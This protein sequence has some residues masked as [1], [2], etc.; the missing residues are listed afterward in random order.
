[1]KFN[2]STTANT[3]IYSNDM[4]LFNETNNS[5]L[6]YFTSF[7]EE[8][9][10]DIITEDTIEHHMTIK[11]KGHTE[12][13]TSR[14]LL[15]PTVSWTTDDKISRQ[16]LRVQLG[17]F[18][19]IASEK[20]DYQD[21]TFVDVGSY[22]SQSYEGFQ[23]P[24]G[25]TTIE[26]KMRVCNKINTCSESN[27]T[28][29]FHVESPVR[30]ELVST[31]ELRNSNVS[32][33]LV[34]MNGIPFQADSG[35]LFHQWSL[36]LDEACKRQISSWKL[37]NITGSTFEVNICIAPETSL[38]TNTYGC[39][40]AFSTAGNE[41]TSCAKTNVSNTNTDRT[42]FDF[43]LTSNAWKHVLE[44]K[45]SSN[46]GEQYEILQ[47][48]ELDFANGKSAVVGVMLYADQRN[49]TWYLVTT[50]TL[51]PSGD[52]DKS[53][54]CQNSLTTGNGYATFDITHLMQNIRYYICAFADESIVEREYSTEHLSS[55]Q[56]CS[57]GFVVDREPPSAGNVL[58][59]N[60]NGFVANL[61]SIKI[62]WKGFADNVHSSM[63][64]YDRD[65]DYYM[66]AIG[67]RRGQD[68][69]M[70]FR[71]VGH[72]HSVNE[73][74]QAVLNGASFFVTVKAVDFAG[75]E[76]KVSS[77]EVLVDTTPPFVGDIHIQSNLYSPRYFSSHILSV[78]LSNFMDHE[79]GIDFFEVCIGTYV[80]LC[81]TVESKQESV[82]VIE[83]AMENALRDGSTYFIN[84]KA[85]NRAG[86]PS[87]TVSRS[88]SFD[89]SPPELG[90]VFDGTRKD[91]TDIDFQNTSTEI[92]IHW[93]GFNDPH[94]GMA[95]YEVGLGTRPF[96]DNVESIINVGLREDFKWLDNF[97][98]GTR[99][100]ATVNACNN[101]GLC[102][103]RTSNG[104][105]ID[106]SP[107]IQGLVSIGS[108]S[109]HHR[110]VANRGSVTVQWVGFQ[111]PES[112]LDHFDICIGD[113]PSNCKY[114]PY[115]HC[116]L[117]N[118]IV[119]TGLSLPENINL[120][121][122]VRAFN[123]A[124]IFTNQ[125]S[126]YFRIDTTAPVIFERPQ[127]RH[128][129]SGVSSNNGQ[130]ER[131]LLKLKWKF[132]DKQ[133]PI[134]SH[135]L[136]LKTHHDGH[137]PVEYLH[138]GNID[139]LTISLHENDLLNNGDKYFVTVTGCNL[140]DLCT[141]AISENITVDSS[142]P[143]VGG[144]KPPLNWN[145]FKKNGGEMLSNVTLTWYGFI[146][147]ES[148]IESYFITLSRTYSGNEL[149]NE[150]IVVTASNQH[151]EMNTSITLVET[152]KP[153]DIVI[154]SIWAMNKIGLNSSVSRTSVL[155]LSG[156]SR[157]GN[158]STGRL[159][160][161]K[162]SCDV[163]FC[164]SD[165]TC[166]VFGKPC[167]MKKDN[168]T[169]NSMN[170]SEIANELPTLRVV[171]GL[172]ET[173]E[174]TTASSNCL[175]G[176]WN[177][178]SGNESAFERYEWSA[179]L[180]NQPIG[181]GSDVYGLTNVGV[182]TQITFNTSSLLHGTRY[183][184]TV[185]SYNILGLHTTGNSDGFMI[186]IDI[187]I[188]GTVFN[189]RSFSN[190][191]FQSST[192]EFEISWY[193]F[194]DHLSGIRS[195]EV[196][197][198]EASE[199]KQDLFSLYFDE[200]A[201]SDSIHLNISECDM[202]IGHVLDVVKVRQIGPSTIRV[203][204]FILD[205]E[206]GIRKWSLGIGTTE[207]GYQL[208]TFQNKFHGSDGIVSLNASHG[209]SIFVTVI[210]ENNAGL[211][212]TLKGNTIKIDRTPPD[213]V[214]IKAEF[215]ASDLNDTIFA[216]W[217]AND[218]ESG[219]AYCSCGLGN[220]GGQSDIIPMQV[221]DSIEGC[222]LVAIENKSE[223]FVNVVCVN[224]M[225]L[226]TFASTKVNV[227]RHVPTT[228][229]AIVN[230]VPLNEYSPTLRDCDETTCTQSNQNKLCLEW[231]G[232]QDVRYISGY[233]YRILVGNFSERKW[234]PCKRHTFTEVNIRMQEN[235]IYTAE[236]RAINRIGHSA[237]VSKD[238]R[239]LP[240]GP[241]LT[242]Q[243][244]KTVF[245]NSTLFLDWQS[246]FEHTEFELRYDVMIGSQSG[247]TDLLELQ[248]TGSLQY[249][250]PVPTSTIVSPVITELHITINAIGLTGFQTRYGFVY[251]Y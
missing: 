7:T 158:I 16:S 193:G 14:A 170:V 194:T 164:N 136:T 19:D 25:V 246:V 86:L 227:I 147:P 81:D 41:M 247:Y 189:T 107:P 169:C 74:I 47:N 243:P 225:E 119:L 192:T 113:S 176:N 217:S 34:H 104:I 13:I 80:N 238:I 11:E 178:I 218:E 50:S 70:H 44:I 224:G 72:V 91:A 6:V 161:V 21:V 115:K 226:E 110:Y 219:I 173:H 211:T 65:I 102:Q 241:G 166:A 93:K 97:Q 182:N 139:K 90:F 108:G 35:I 130:W 144:F 206:S 156:S 195:Y 215:R 232:F 64:G 92:H 127:I 88:L 157:H 18:T 190:R 15:N 3:K 46:V 184:C 123:K 199:T 250:V 33:L 153:D 51:P 220:V 251:R 149:S 73:D 79:S 151:S 1:M 23:T 59:E 109:K 36:C 117:R 31:S 61:R 83:I 118:S 77:D 146:D 69:I 200:N 163:H 167:T 198:V 203:V 248:N 205:R 8:P 132:E 188:Q 141:E 221:S 175:S 39:I 75:H 214:E 134:V 172:T 29:I 103:K 245:S 231:T 171:A 212:S 5:E 2:N 114:L 68:D 63:M 49:L 24:K 142:P 67:H 82:D 187:P 58:I 143:H 66:L 60:T 216:R 78:R 168:I 204:P 37:L 121:V 106:P 76:T 96:V 236:V 223:V 197:Y 101:A 235:V 10:F 32:C 186:D 22:L 209:T 174:G 131:S 129:M 27:L 177:I 111:D 52:C 95:Y 140:A 191:H 138:V 126:D 62:Y 94:S 53:S 244:V 208:Q 100:Y 40:R 239:S 45:H 84:V 154:I 162:H 48:N 124:K 240:N 57:D 17:M 71:N 150:T 116:Q 237:E 54:Q 228:D 26:I 55:I 12:F 229:D 160:L 87:R 133:S 249:T 99:Y 234:S 20:T 207:N 196:A 155:A 125:T 89:S 152:I 185:S 122:T 112:G 230:V 43:E 42:I 28:Q 210:V 213:V 201:K 56:E 180:T 159:E 222:K 181:E 128:D 179:G 4:L 137:T 145:T 9:C 105:V 85:F 120:F 165:C 242:G 148:E 38:K 233:E 98:H 135:I 30:N 183:Y 202:D